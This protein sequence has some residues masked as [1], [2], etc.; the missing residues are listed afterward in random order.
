D[1]GLRGTY[2]EELIH[3]DHRVLHMAVSEE[4]WVLE[5]EPQALDDQRC[6]ARVLWDRERPDWMA[7]MA[8][9]L[10]NF[11][12]YGSFWLNQV[13]KP[14]ADDL[15]SGFLHGTGRNLWSVL[16]NWKSAPIRYQ[17]QFDWV[18]QRAREAFPELMGSLEFDRGLPYLFLPD[19]TD[20]GD[21]LP[22]MRAADGLLTGLL[23]LTAVAG[24]KRGSIIAF[25]EIE[26]Q[27][28]PHAIRQIL[29][30][31]RQLAEERDLTIIVTSHSPV[32]M[33]TFRDEPDR[34]F[35]LQPRAETS[36][37]ALTELHD[38][39]WLA[40]FALGDLY[41]RL[42]FAAPTLIPAEATEG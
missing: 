11:R 10:A 37:T 7:P 12:V 5:G 39:D 33:N 21:G 4:Q 34:F 29:R 36:P 15:P 13:R 16:Q 42:E 30:A 38:E 41:D 18:T 17:G 14:A 27:L 1:V 40:A 28:H 3:A 9:T 19:A 20:P 32:V 2:G 23:Q 26:N 24:A 31:M 25:D 22:P 35:V 6:C 8:E